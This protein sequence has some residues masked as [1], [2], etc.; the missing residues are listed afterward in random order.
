MP[1]GIEIEQ[2]KVNYKMNLI[3]EEGAYILIIDS[4]LPIA[5][6]LF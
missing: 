1:A 5:S 3:A 2:F 4:K 6:I